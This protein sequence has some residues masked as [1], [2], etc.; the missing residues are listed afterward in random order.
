[1]RA[2]AHA[3]SWYEDALAPEAACPPLHGRVRADVAVL[4]AGLTGLNAALE[5]AGR[6]YRVVLVEAAR[7][8]AGGSGR[9]GGQV[10]A[11]YA[12]G[13]ATLH[14]TLGRDAA[15]QLWQASIDAVARVKQHIDTCAIACDWRD[16]CATLALKPRQARALRDWQAQAERDYGHSGLRW[17]DAGELDGLI[18]S[19]RYCGALFDT[20][21][22]HLQPLAY[23]RALA[24]AAQAAGV[25]LHED[26]PVLH[27]ERGPHA[28]LH[29]KQGAVEAGQLVIAGGALP[30]RLVP[31]LAATVLPV[32]TYIVAT[33]PLGAE[34]AAA[35][36]P[37]DAAV[38]DANFVLDYFRRSA[39]HRL[40]FGGRVSYSGLESPGLAAGMRQRL[41]AVFPQLPRQ[42]AITHAW[43]G[44]VDITAN[45]AP[46]I[47]RLGD[48]LWYAQGFSG[49]GMALAN[50]AGAVLAEAIA[51]QCERFDVFARIPHRA[52]PGGGR[53][54]VPLLMLAM[55]AMRLRD[56]L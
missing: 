19:P 20:G 41:L 47:G 56:C 55:L 4:G 13:M 51:G 9:S 25:V 22:G 8:G 38:C 1:M 21:A 45:R 39:D 37:S 52:F 14:A 40:L 31:E 46:D 7:I 28:V 6:G 53:L 42:L 2:L 12:C 43:G 35:L 27:I 15:V 36:L 33:E 30:A 34:R 3:R 5:L 16:G 24:R 18:A 29:T 44:Y 49:H 10:L 23:T 17:L 50:L 54:R 26:S 11:D 32:G 48:N